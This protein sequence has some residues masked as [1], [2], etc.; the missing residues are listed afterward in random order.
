MAGG[1]ESNAIVDAIDA[2]NL[3]TTHAAKGLEFPVVFLVHLQRGSGGSP[4]PIRVLPAPFGSARH[5]EPSVSIG[6]HESD[7]DR[8]LERA[9]PRRASVSSMSR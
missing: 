4:D 8:D 7:G 2:V 1:D 5:V 3:M 9:R 6:A